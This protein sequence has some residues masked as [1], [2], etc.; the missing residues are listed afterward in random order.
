MVGR[1]IENEDKMNLISDGK[2]ID[3]KIVGPRDTRNIRNNRFTTNGATE[4]PSMEME[5]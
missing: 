2:K 4:S 3:P 1:E 5:I